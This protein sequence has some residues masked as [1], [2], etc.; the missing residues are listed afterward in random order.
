M[1]EEVIKFLKEKYG[2]ICPEYDNCDGCEEID[3]KVNPIN[4]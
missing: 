1:K 4:N 3:C 2:I